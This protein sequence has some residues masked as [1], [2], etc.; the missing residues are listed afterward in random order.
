[1][2]A[3]SCVILSGLA[4]FDYDIHHF[5]SPKAIPTALFAST[6]QPLAA[7][8]FGTVTGQ[9]PGMMGCLTQD[10]QVTSLCH[11]IAVG[12]S[13]CWTVYL[14]GYPSM[15]DP[16]VPSSRRLQDDSCGI[17]DCAQKRTY[18]YWFSRAFGGSHDRA[19]KEQV[20]RI[21]P[22]SNIIPFHASANPIVQ[23]YS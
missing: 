6:A 14:L 19:S 8:L 15:L 9:L 4:L 13:S 1:M 21:Y 5:I 10:L 23:F 20:P 3:K 7:S 18:T 16:E 11:D 17:Q 12:Q 22:S 2:S